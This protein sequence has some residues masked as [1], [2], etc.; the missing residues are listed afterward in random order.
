MDFPCWPVDIGVALNADFD[1]LGTGKA[2]VIGS[3]HQ[4]AISTWL[5]IN[6]ETVETA[7]PRTW[8]APP[9]PN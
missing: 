2:L 4:C 8:V 3:S 9:F 6:P 7:T 1:H 5:S